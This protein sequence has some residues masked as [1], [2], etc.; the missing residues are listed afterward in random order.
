MHAKVLT[1]MVRPNK[2]DEFIEIFE[3]VILPLVQSTPGFEELHFL[4]SKDGKVMLITLWKDERSMREGRIEEAL[5]ND[6]REY[7]HV[8]ANR[9]L[10]EVYEVMLGS[11]PE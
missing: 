5:K 9:P 8:F 10:E 6:L 2:L 1:Y 4:K 7:S 11:E 3:A